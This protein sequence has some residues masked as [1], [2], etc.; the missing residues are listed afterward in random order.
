MSG[1]II[2]EEKAEFIATMKVILKNRKIVMAKYKVP[3]S[4]NNQDKIDF[5]YAIHFKRLVSWK[6]GSKFHNRTILEQ[7]IILSEEAIFAFNEIFMRLYPIKENQ[8][9]EKRVTNDADPEDGIKPK[10]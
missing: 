3:E 9:K 6:E 5:Y 4:W 10:E 2:D 8:S 7:S 1:Q